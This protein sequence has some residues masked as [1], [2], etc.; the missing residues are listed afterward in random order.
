[1]S[2]SGGGDTQ[3]PCRI[4]DIVIGSRRLNQEVIALVS[5]GHLHRESW[6][7]RARFLRRLRDNQHFESLCRSV[8]WG[9]EET[10]ST[11]VS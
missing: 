10:A 5:R 7:F 6:S 1:M 4:V 3:M 8:V 11:N 2:L 9:T